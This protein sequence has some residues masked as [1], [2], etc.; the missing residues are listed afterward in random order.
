MIQLEQHPLYYLKELEKRE[1]LSDP[2]Q[3]FLGQFVT[4]TEKHFE[5][6]FLSKLP[7]QY[8]SLD[9]ENM[10]KPLITLVHDRVFDVCSQLKLQISII[11]SCAKQPKRLVVSNATIKG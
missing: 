6:V 9:A 1:R 4:L 3:Q 5:D 11:L 10:G 7:E 2:E 8:Q